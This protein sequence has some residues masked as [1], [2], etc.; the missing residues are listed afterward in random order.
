MGPPFCP[1]HEFWPLWF[2]ALPGPFLASNVVRLG[3]TI[4]S[5]PAPNHRPWLPFLE[6][7]Q[8]TPT[9]SSLEQSSLGNLEEPRNHGDAAIFP[10]WSPL[11]GKLGHCSSF[12]PLEG[13]FSQARASP[14]SGFGALSTAPSPNHAG[15][16]W[17]LPDLSPFDPR[18]HCLRLATPSPPTRAPLSLLQA[19]KAVR[20]LTQLPKHLG[21]EGS[22]AGSERATHSQPVFLTCTRMFG[23]L[24][25][26]KKKN[27]NTDVIMSQPCQWLPIR[28]GK[29]PQVFLKAAG[30]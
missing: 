9:G 23:F 25:F 15:V 26:F 11:L 6:L 28:L 10:R 3:S 13:D 24:S 16:L 27:Q 20:R 29:R 18:G 12:S 14:L 21:L 22:G 7:R 2:C 30:L 17:P 4:T 8:G 1:P 19:S 5:Q